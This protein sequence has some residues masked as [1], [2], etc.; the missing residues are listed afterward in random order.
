MVRWSSYTCLQDRRIN[1]REHKGSEP[2]Q[3]NGK[4]SRRIYTL[5]LL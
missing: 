4:Y 2:D 1:T 5:Y 3:G